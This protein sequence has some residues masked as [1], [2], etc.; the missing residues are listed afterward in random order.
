MVREIIIE[1]AEGQNWVTKLKYY[2]TGL[3]AIENIKDGKTTRVYVNR[4]TIVELWDFF[5]K[6]R[7]Y[8]ISGANWITALL[9]KLGIVKIKIE[10]EM[11]E[12]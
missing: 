10:T 1:K 8:K 6:N 5:S 4:H 2:D 11:K 3:G 12:K 9:I 7:F